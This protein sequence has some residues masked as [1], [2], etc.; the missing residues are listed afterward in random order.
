MKSGTN[1]PLVIRDEIHGDISFEGIARDVIDHE[2]FQRLR[3]IKQLGLAEFVFPC[4]THTRF[5][6]SLGAGYLAGQYF[7]TMVKAWLTSP[8]EKDEKCGTSQLFINRTKKCFYEVATDSRSM[9]FWTDVSILSGLLHDVGHGPWSHTFEYLELD[10]DFSLITNKM[11][12]CARFYFQELAR[13][14]QSLKHE[15]ISIVYIFRILKDLEKDGTLENSDAYFLSVASLVNKKMT[16]GKFSASF[17]T[18]LQAALKKQKIRGGIDIHQLIRPLISGPFDVDRI[19]YI[20]RDGRNS[21]VQIGGIEWRRIVTKVIPCLASHPNTDGEPEDVVL[22]SNMKN[23]HVLDDFIFSLFQMYAQVYLHP[24]IVGIE[25][26]ARKELQKRVS[27]RQNPKITFEVHRCL[28]DEKFRAMLKHDFRATRIE[29]VLLRQKG[30]EFHVGRYPKD[31]VLEKELIKNGFKLVE[32]SE[33]PMMKDSLGVYL[34]SILKSSKDLKSKR[35]YMKE[36]TTI[37]ELA[38]RFFSI[39]YSPRVW[40]QREWKEK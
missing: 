31:P 39:Y 18:E 30:L 11:E 5:Q 38:D 8:L 9:D 32:L 14:K 37:S 28:T 20:Q 7:E 26:I 40:V 4:A 21:G 33:R 35:C 17:R 25:E 36:W 34:Y 27:S 3:S 12:G 15:D 24:K 13:T 16:Q 1:K 22:I 10:L 23:Q 19:D 2:D 29:G 6:H